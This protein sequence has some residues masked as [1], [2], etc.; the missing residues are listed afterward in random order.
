MSDHRPQPDGPS[1]VS[2]AAFVALARARRS[3]SPRR[4]GVPAP[5]LDQ[6]RHFAEAAVTAPD[7]GLLRPWR[8]LMIDDEY[9]ALLADA[10][11]C[12]EYELN[13]DAAPE[14][15]ARARD[16]ALA[17]PRLVAVVAVTRSGRS[18]VPVEEQLVSVGAALQN[19]L[20]A[21]RA[22]GY[23]S[24]IVSGEKTST[25]ALRIVFG[26]GSNEHLIGFVALGTVTSPPPVKSRPPVDDHFA[27][28]PHCLSAIA[29][30]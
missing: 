9:R 14:S 6:I 3:V 12:A 19:F 4:L 1:P 23:A 28:W 27:I 30:R 2:L 17:G 22:A 20:L 29:G 25:T 18:D 10:F 13:P 7:H 26:L 11:A 21:A 15:L 16:K 24:M 8:F 5:T